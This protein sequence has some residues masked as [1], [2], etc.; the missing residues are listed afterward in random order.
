[1]KNNYIARNISVLV[2][3]AIIA[4]IA[5]LDFLRMHKPDP[6]NISNPNISEIKML[7]EWSPNLKDTPYDTEVYVI[8]GAKEGGTALLLGGTHPNEIAAML[9]AVTYIENATVEQGTVY[10]IPRLNNSGFSHTAPLRGQ[11]DIAKFTLADGSTREFRMGTR[12]SNPIHQWPDMNYYNGASGRE[13]K[14][15]ENAEIRNLNRN[16]PGNPDGTTTEKIAYGVRNLIDTEKVDVLYDGHEAGPEFL[17]VNFT[18]AHERAM[19]LASLATMNSNIDGFPFKVEISG[20]TSFG[21]S[22]RALGDNTQVLATLFE[23]LNPCMGTS[24]SKVTEDLVLRGIDNNYVE[25]T[26]AGLLS[27][28]EL[29]EDGSPIERRAGYHMAISGYMMSTLGEM[30]PAKAITITGMPTFEQMSTNGLGSTLKPIK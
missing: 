6:I 30:D 21:L 3:A 17:R 20:A 14:N 8:R 25:M 26:K 4:G 15:T 18:I 19:P 27:S 12:L 11:M 28:G 1:M 10:I 16:H 22:H 2:L 5:S 23:T 9:S 24:H 7:S 13:L 29:Y